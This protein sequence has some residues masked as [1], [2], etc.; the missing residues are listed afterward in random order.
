MNK[1]E[2]CKQFL[3]CNLYT[4]S[5]RQETTNPDWTFLKNQ[6]QTVF[7]RFH[8][9]KEYWASFLVHHHSNIA[10]ILYKMLDEKAVR[11]S[12]ILY[13]SQTSQAQLLFIIYL[14][15]F[16]QLS[17]RDKI[18]YVFSQPLQVLLIFDS[19][20]FSALSL[21][22]CIN[23]MDVALESTPSPYKWHFQKPHWRLLVSDLFAN[24][25]SKGLSKL[26]QTVYLRRTRLGQVVMNTPTEP[27]LPKMSVPQFG[28]YRLRHT[29]FLSNHS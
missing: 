19:N 28:I 11:F 25:P 6:N 16:L 24:T 29:P 9:R 7:L 15:F 4:S 21:Y 23:G 12:F 18:F 27:E 3:I 13:L 10:S 22:A 14:S 17:N 2:H 1:I 8:H 20:P 5:K 26:L